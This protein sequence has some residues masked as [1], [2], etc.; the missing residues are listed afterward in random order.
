VALF[1][2]GSNMKLLT[3]VE[4][5]TLICKA[6]EEVIKHGKYYRYGQALWNLLP[7]EISDKFVGTS[8]DFFYEGDNEKVVAMFYGNYVEKPQEEKILFYKRTDGNVSLFYKGI[9]YGFSTIINNSEYKEYCKNMVKGYRFSPLPRQEKHT[10][11]PK[12]LD[13]ALIGH[14]TEREG[15]VI[16]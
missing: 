10:S 16:Y 3:R 9:H 14:Y 6:N 5:D 12:D 8:V 13:S 11:M 1:L 7:K 2:G 4:A 15:I